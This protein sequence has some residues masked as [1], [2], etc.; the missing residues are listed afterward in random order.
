LKA[1]YLDTKIL[2]IIT[3]FDVLENQLLSEE[4]NKKP[5]VGYLCLRTPVELI[6]AMGATPIRIVPTP[7]FNVYD[8]GN[9]RPDGCSFCRMLPSFLKTEKYKNLSAII[10]GACCDQMRRAMDTLKRD[11]DIP[12]FLYTAPRTFNQGTSFFLNEMKSS[13]EQLAE[14]LDL[15]IDKGLAKDYIDARNK[16]RERINCLRESGSL[17]DSLLHRI[18]ASSLASG[19]ILDLLDKIESIKSDVHS[20]K[21]MLAGSIPGTWELAEIEKTGAEVVAD[22]TCMGDRAYKDLDRRDGDPFENLYDVYIENN[23]CPHRRPI[24]NLLDY[25]HDLAQSRKID[26]VIYLTLKYCHPWGLSA[27]RM[28]KTLSGIHFMKL[29]DDLTSPA[30]SN[31]RT[32]VG[33]FIEMLQ[34]KKIEQEKRAKIAV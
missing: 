5:L 26:G 21:I 6:E 9:I 1:I 27:E 13:F 16:L 24:T 4:A 31:F 29:D 14:S 25:I 2:N 19:S 18:S 32:R 7:G 20:P 22:V 12:V 10:G 30:L 28:R 8:Y 17:P 11:M 34:A 3:K 23:L 33:A 15:E